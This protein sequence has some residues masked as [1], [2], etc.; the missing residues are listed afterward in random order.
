M[1]LIENFDEFLD[2]DDFAVSATYTPESGSGT[3]INGIFD[4]EYLAV[5]E[6]MVGVMSSSPMF[7]TQTSN[8]S[9]EDGSGNLQVNGTTYNIIEVKPDGT[10]MTHLILAEQS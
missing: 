4:A 3:S 6:G 5:E 2:T 8:V 7:L 1:S 9:S 10:G